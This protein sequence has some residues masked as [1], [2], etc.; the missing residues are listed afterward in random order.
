MN[1]WFFVFLLF[2]CSSLSLLLFFFLLL[3]L[4]SSL[5]FKWPVDT[6]KLLIRFGDAYSRSPSVPIS[7]RRV[8]AK[9]VWGCGPGLAW[10]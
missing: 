5:L 3:S 4:L 10:T 8:R 6:D 1:L 9:E 2:G 7:V